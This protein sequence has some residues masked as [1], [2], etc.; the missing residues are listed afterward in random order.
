MQVKYEATTDANANQTATPSKVIEVT[1][2]PQDTRE[3]E[4]VQ[5]AVPFGKVTNVAI[6]RNKNKVRAIRNLIF[7]KSCRKFQF[8]GIALEISHFD[9]VRYNVCTA[10]MLQ[11][12]TRNL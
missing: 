9:G 10:N 8:D 1:S 2:V 11:H 7:N 6:A 3:A 12:E 4:L 5:I